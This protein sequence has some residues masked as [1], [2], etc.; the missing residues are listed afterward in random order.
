[1][2][3]QAINEPSQEAQFITEY[4]VGELPEYHPPVPSAP[5]VEE[6]VEEDSEE[7]SESQE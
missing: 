4:I 3:Q 1:L 6:P 2:I 5:V 7:S